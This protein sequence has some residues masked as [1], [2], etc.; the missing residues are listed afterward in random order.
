[1]EIG[2][3]GQGISAEFL[4]HVFERFRQA[5]SST[6]RKHGGLGLGLAIVRHLTEIHGGTVHA[7]SDGEG[8]GATLTVILPLLAD[9]EAVSILDDG[10]EITSAFRSGQPDLAGIHVLVV[11]DDAGA[12]EMISAALNERHARVTAVASAREALQVIRRKRPDVL[13]S[14]IAMPIEDGYDLIQQIRALEANNGKLI[15]A[16]AMT[17][18][19]REEDRQ[20]ALASG[21]QSYLAKPIEPADLIAVVASLTR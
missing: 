12:R 8:K 15:P 20:R 3:N 17:A 11:D 1:L 21:F 16:V 18:Y 5:D 13:V 2:D 14:D 10:K 9:D 6:T 7:E 19:A 4:P